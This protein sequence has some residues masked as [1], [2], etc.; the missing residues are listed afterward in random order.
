MKLTEEIWMNRFWTLALDSGH[1]E[2][3]RYW[4]FRIAQ[5]RR[6]AHASK[7]NS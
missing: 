2:L 1:T 6:E 5:L 4:M 3:A 7:T